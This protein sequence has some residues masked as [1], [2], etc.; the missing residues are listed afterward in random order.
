MDGRG[1]R[2]RKTGRGIGSAGMIGCMVRVALKYGAQWDVTAFEKVDM[3][4]TA[5]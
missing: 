4:Q 5:T 1:S 2:R 3:I